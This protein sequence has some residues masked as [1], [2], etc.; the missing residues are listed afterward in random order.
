MPEIKK[1]DTKP[2]IRGI[3]FLTLGVLAVQTVL[4]LTGAEA[5]K[6]VMGIFMTLYFAAAAIL[7]AMAF[8]DRTGHD[9]YSYDII[10]Y[11]A[12][13]LLSLVLAALSGRMTWLFISRP[14]VYTAAGI[15]YSMAGAQWTFLFLSAPFLLIFSLGL[16]ISNIEL[17]RREGRSFVNTL[18]ILLALALTGG[19]A[20]LY[21]IN[22]YMSGSMYEVM[23]REA[24]TNLLALV[25]IY[26][27]CMLLGV[28]AAN[29]H[30]VRHEPE[31]DRDFLIILGCAVRRDGSPTP[32]LK[33]R[34]DRA[35]AFREKQMSLTGK[36]PVFVASRGQGAD[37]AVS[38]SECMK[39]YLIS[40]GIREERILKEDRSAS[41]FE[42]MKFSGGKIRE[43]DPEGKGKIAFSTNGYHVFRSGLLAGQAGVRAEGMGAGTRWYFWPN[44]AVREF[45]GILTEHRRQQAVIFICMAVISLSL[46]ILRYYIY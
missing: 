15:L 26:V 13:A 31:P 24:V 36:E 42:N 3:L 35:L 43:A 5:H 22:M 12:F 34:L 30:A 21:R 27:E 16:C 32:L 39:R 46:T 41:T 29:V 40:R 9:P 38:E 45:I 20:F 25:Y 6:T 14:E 1:R 44:A 4:I 19:F 7:L 8:R 10:Y 23:A 33:A 17:L 2:D 11:A 18:G 28:M 37:E